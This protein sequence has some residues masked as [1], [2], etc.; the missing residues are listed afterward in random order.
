MDSANTQ[1]RNVLPDDAAVAQSSTR[2]FPP[3]VIAVV[4]G[5]HH[6]KLHARTRN[7]V[8]TSSKTPLAP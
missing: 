1:P 6:G 7:R 5:D 8:R 3:G 2:A 4:Y